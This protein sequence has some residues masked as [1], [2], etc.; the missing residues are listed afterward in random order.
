MQLASLETWG[1]RLSGKTCRPSAEA[2]IGSLRALTDTITPW[3]ILI[4]E[5]RILSRQCKSFYHRWPG[6]HPD[7]GSLGTSLVWLA[8][9]CLWKWKW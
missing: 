7:L 9:L 2:N 6:P 3:A 1:T 4:Q 5:T 8:E